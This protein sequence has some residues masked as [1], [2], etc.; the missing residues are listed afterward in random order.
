M[1]GGR[2]GPHY[3]AVL[4]PD[5]EP[6]IAQLLR[7]AAGVETLRYESWRKKFFWPCVFEELNPEKLCELPDYIP[8]V[9]AGSPAPRTLS[10]WK[11][12]ALRII[13]RCEKNGFVTREDFRS[14]GIDMR[15]WTEG[16]WLKPI[17]KG[18]WSLGNVDFHLKHPT[19]Y[20]QIIGEART[21][22]AKES[23]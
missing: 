16:D 21:I 7:K 10:P 8:D 12:A 9:V 11:V 1:N 18:Q 13:A 5:S 20:A 17:G 15:R 23:V 22:T 3:R 4:V 2:V 6:T 19:V 14:C